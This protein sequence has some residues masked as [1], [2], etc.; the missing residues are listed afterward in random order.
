MFRYPKEVLDILS[1]SL[2]ENVSKEVVHW[3]E[4]IHGWKEKSD[5]EAESGE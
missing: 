1:E 2:G 3:P 4:Q 5:N